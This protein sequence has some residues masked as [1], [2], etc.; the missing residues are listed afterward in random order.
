VKPPGEEVW[1]QADPTRLVQIVSNLVHNAV[2][3]TPRGGVI[4]L[5]S[6]VDEGDAVLR[7]ADTGVGI[8]REM[9]KLIFEPFTQ[10]DAS[11]TRGHGG[12]GIGL[13][14]ARRLAVLHD[15]GLRADSE[16]RGR[17]STL[18]LRL[19]RIATPSAAAKAAAAEE[20]AAATREGAKNGAPR[21]I[22]VVDDNHDSA[23]SLADLL[24]I[25][26]HEVEIA[27]DGPSALERAEE[28]RPD[29]VLLD[30]GLP[31]MD[32]YEVAER[33][34]ARR[35]S[36]ELSLIA[37]TGLGR[38]EDRRRALEAGFDHHLT[39]PI[40]PPALREL[41]ERREN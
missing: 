22:L 35:K 18:T 4:E 14:L 34:R 27:H 3:Y 17:G 12:L 13:T 11:M 19:P 8:P 5:S 9:L 15:G 26:G 24:R 10:V 32:G 33:L 16:G 29:L 6:G 23:Q 41:L 1:V 39:K 38:Q 40:S 30:I 25:W 20:R 36:D 28:G 21:R 7:V 31:G 2:K 37:L